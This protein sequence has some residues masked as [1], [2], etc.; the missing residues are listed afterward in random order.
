MTPGPDGEILDSLTNKKILELRDAVLKNEF[1]WTGVRELHIPKPGKPGKF[2]PL[3]IPA[4]NDRLVQEVIRTVIEPIFELNFSNKSHGFRPNRNCH[5]ALKWINTNMKDSTWFI[6]GDIQSYFPT[7]DHEIIMKLISKRIQ[8]PMILRLIKTG[9]K[10]K[11]FQEDW[12]AYIP[13]LGTPQGGIISP[14]LSNIYLDEFD[15]YMEELSTQYLGEVKP[16]NRKKNPAALKLLRSG[17]KGEYY[18]LRMP[19]RI[20][21]EVGYRNCKYTRY[22]D[23]FVIGILGPR[24]MALEIREKV[25][26]FLK[27]ELNIELSMEK[28]KITH[29][30]EGIE[31]LGY[32]FSRKKHFVRQKYGRKVVLRKMTIPTLDV[33]IRRVIARLAQTTFCDGKGTPKPAFRFLRLPQSETNLKVNYIL[34]GLSEWW[35]IAGNR[36][37]TVARVAYIIRH[38]IAKVYAAKFKLPTVAAVF[39]IGGNDLSKPIGARIKS[40]IGADESNT[41]KGHKVKLEGIL[42]DRYYK[43]PR[44][45]SNKI[46]PNWVP[47]HLIPWRA[48]KWGIE[49]FVEHLWKTKKSA[50]KNPLAAMAWRLEKSLSSQGAPCAICGSYEEVQ[51][52]H[53][54]PLKDIPKSA[55]AIKRHAIAI[56]RKQIPLCRK[57]HLEAHKGDWNNNPAKSQWNQSSV[58]EPCN[59]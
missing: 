23:D 58:G 46:K 21:N 41:P 59:G 35:S 25:K 40:V 15:K 42:Y 7:I 37:Q 39:K 16:G 19:S 52:H 10:A 5:T 45:Q 44:T 26:I 4:I 6:E 47:E 50:S 49:E 55:N 51:M 54:R 31:F 29:I 27:N 18:R 8:D 30:T 22:A 57:H 43:I 11:V 24:S 20:H 48:S 38:S 36:R 53:K 13:E 2:R 1:A 56:Q 3:G 34:R 14:L 33:N 9:L 12:K 17:R 28:T 32:K